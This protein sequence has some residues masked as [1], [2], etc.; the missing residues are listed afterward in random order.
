MINIDYLGLKCGICN[1]D[2]KEDDDVVVCPDCGTPMH[3]ICYKENQVCP[4]SEKHS[5]GY[6]FDGFDKIKESA[7]GKKVELKKNDDTNGSSQNFI[8]SSGEII[9]PL[10]GEKNKQGAN[11]CNRCGSRFL[12]SSESLNVELKDPFQ[13][14]EQ[15][16][17]PAVASAA[18]GIDP[19]A[20]VPANA[21]FE[22][23]VLAADLACYVSVNTPY[24]LRAFDAIKR[25][26]NRFNFSAAIFSG[27]WFLYRKLYKIGALIFS[28][29]MLLY[30]IRFY[31][32]ATYS[33][34]IMKKLFE[35]VGLS[36]DQMSSL[37]MSQYAELADAMMKL[38]ISEQLVMMIPSIM[39]VL[40]IIIMIVCGFTA[41]KSYYRHCVSRVKFI[42]EKA[43]EA[44]FNLS[45]TSKSLYLSGGISPF[46][47]G[48]FGLVYILIM[49]L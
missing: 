37:S 13:N 31:F 36:V 8:S 3:R 18:Y 12:K 6:V 9:C 5:E 35:A 2:F 1:L 4:N 25:R 24:Y 30:A 29:E 32:S 26:A 41:N 49:I 43:R 11:F 19:L 22:E 14:E 46:V 15:I 20:G 38:P 21:E 16:P 44:G 39:F 17:N 7:Q 40:Q 10:C 27:V 45:D 47:A 48:A 33:M 23:N 34:D 28:L 42:K